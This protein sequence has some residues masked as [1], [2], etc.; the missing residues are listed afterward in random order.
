MDCGRIKL[1][2]RELSN[3]CLIDMQKDYK[4]GH[5]L[6]ER[7]LVVIDSLPKIIQFIGSRNK[8]DKDMLLELNLYGHIYTIVT[9]LHGTYKDD[10]R[11][12]ISNWLND[13]YRRINLTMRQIPSNLK[14][15][16]TVFSH[17][18]RRCDI[19]KNDYVVSQVLFNR[20]R[21][22]ERYQIVYRLNTFPADISNF[23][24]QILLELYIKNGVV[25]M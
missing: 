9:Q 14:V 3:Y 10:E 5:T 4:L 8:I 2:T 13:T 20:S 16:E 23:I 21:I 18:F 25:L 24:C 17:A 19:D 7:K 1:K 11:R 15:L 12:A 6:E 22:F